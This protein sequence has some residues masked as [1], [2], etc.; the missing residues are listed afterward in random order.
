MGGKLGSTNNPVGSAISGFGPGVLKSVAQP[1]ILISA[2]ESYFLQAEAT[3]RTFL[4]GNVQTLF[5][6]GVQASFDYLGAAGALAYY[7]QANKN[8]NYAATTNPAEQ[9]AVIIRQKWVANNTVMPLEAFND[10]RRLGLPSDIPLS[11]STFVDVRT[12]PT[13]YLYPTVEYSTNAANVAAQGTINHHTSKIFW[14]P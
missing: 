10:Y 14:M 4:P 3:F 2:A 7:S 1:S 13:R 9:L 12:I 5:N 6:S 8:T 11:V